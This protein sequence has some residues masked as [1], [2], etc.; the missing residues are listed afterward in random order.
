M[1]HCHGTDLKMDIPTG[2]RKVVLAGN[3]NTGKSVFFNH[4]TGLYVD[5]SNA[6]AWLPTRLKPIRT[7][8]A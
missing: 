2:A 8:Y 1:A 4:F 5:A 7:I 3:P 6:S